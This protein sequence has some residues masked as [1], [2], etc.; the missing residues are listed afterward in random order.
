MIAKASGGGEYAVRK[1]DGR[2]VDRETRQEAVETNERQLSPGGV[3]SK[4]L[5]SLRS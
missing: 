1:G 5:I 4:C 2:A 3:C